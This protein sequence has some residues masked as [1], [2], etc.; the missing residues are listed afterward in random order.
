[1]VMEAMCLAQSAEESLEE[2]VF[3]RNNSIYKQ[4]YTYSLMDAIRLLTYK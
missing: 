2:W 4:Y 3:R 1:M